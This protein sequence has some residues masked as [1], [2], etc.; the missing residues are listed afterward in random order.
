[1]KKEIVE[2]FKKIGRLLFDEHLVHASSGNISMLDGDEI[3]ITRSGALLSSLE[4]EDLVRVGIEKSDL[5]KGASMELP[6]H[7]EIYKSSKANAI[8]HAHPVN[9]I[10]LSQ[11]EEKI[12]P[13]DA[14]GKFYLK[15]IPVVRVHDPIGSEEVL[16]FL[17]PLV[18]SGYQAVMVRGHGSFT[19]GETMLDAYRLSSTLENICKIILLSKKPAVQPAAQT[20]SIRSRGTGMRGSAIPPGIGV[21][22]RSRSGRY[23]NNR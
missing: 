21:M 20:S 16:K 14:E 12:I 10:A 22:D 19:L 11:N 8:I 3:L 4:E 13:Q 23:Q 15:S 5:D 6:V 17:L 2:E 1:M 7:R 9:A 18:S